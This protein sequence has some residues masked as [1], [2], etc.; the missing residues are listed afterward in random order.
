MTK[1]D[2]ED[3]VSKKLLNDRHINYA[4]TLLHNQFPKAEG[5]QNTLLQNR[6]RPV[7]FI[8]GIWVIHDRGCHLVVVTTN[9]KSVTVYDSVYS[10]VTKGTMD[11]INNIFDTNET[12]V[13]NM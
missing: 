6:K 4:Q 8:S 10:T 2:K 3:I 13:A 1:S 12:K 7:K 11:V 5:L 9:D